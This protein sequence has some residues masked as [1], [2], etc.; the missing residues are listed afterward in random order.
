MA[1]THRPWPTVMDG[2]KPRVDQTAVT[3]LSNAIDGLERR[4]AF[5]AIDGRSG[6]GK[7]TLARVMVERH[8]ASL[9]Q[10]DDFYRVI[11]PNVRA[12]LTPVEGVDLYFDW[13]RV[14]R[15]AIE[16]LSRGDTARFQ[17]YD[18][19]ANQL[20]SWEHVTAA[21]VVIIEGVYSARLELADLMDLRVLVETPGSVRHERQ[22]LRNEN[23]ADWI[24]RWGAAEELYFDDILP[25]NPA[26][27]VVVG[28]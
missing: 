17:R 25:G 16:P 10:M 1:V 20:G 13:Q 24:A 4:P 3:Q 9:I 28:A 8:R 2:R 14:R 26:D 22:V 15:E 5:V 18:W 27:L 7:S 12:R 11:D 21:N 6:A 23:G 19:N